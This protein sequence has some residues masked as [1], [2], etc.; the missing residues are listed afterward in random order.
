MMFLF[1]YRFPFTL[2]FLLRCRCRFRFRFRFRFLFPFLFLFR[3]PVSDFSRRPYYVVQTSKGVQG[4]FSRCK[5]MLTPLT[6][7]GLHFLSKQSWKPFYQFSCRFWR[8]L[9]TLKPLITDTTSISSLSFL[10]DLE[11]PKTNTK[12]TGF[13]KEERHGF[14]ELLEEG[15]VDSF[16][17]FYPDKPKQYSFWSYM[18]NARAKNVGW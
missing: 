13:T 12:N 8:T 17:H 3:I 16:S 10:K 18:R 9:S 5:P 14:T 2:L 15:F 1:L 11:N 6:N 4:V 7:N